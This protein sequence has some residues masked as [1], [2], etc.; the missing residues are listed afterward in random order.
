MPVVWWITKNFSKYVN[1]KKTPK[2]NVGLLL[3]EVGHLTSM[4]EDK[5]RDV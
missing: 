4:D 5:A 3:D 2:V 1:N